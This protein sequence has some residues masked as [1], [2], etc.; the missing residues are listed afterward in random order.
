MVTIR[1]EMDT[2]ISKIN[3]MYMDLYHYCLT[4]N[5]NDEVKKHDVIEELRLNGALLLSL[6]ADMEGDIVGHIAF[7][8]VKI[9]DNDSKWVK[10]GPV[11][12]DPKHQKMG[13]GTKLVNEGIDQLRLL[14]YDGVIVFEARE[15]FERFGFSN[16]PSLQNLSTKTEDTY[17][18]ALN[19]LPPRGNVTFHS[20]FSR[21]T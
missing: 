11:N 7:S 2:D 5:A 15:C 14:N 3:A 21:A 16:K 12:V 13:I 20:A 1:K 19:A 17:A 8:P 10:L 6:V 18:I 9:N 4:Q